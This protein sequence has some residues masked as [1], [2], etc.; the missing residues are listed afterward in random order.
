MS[1]SAP[2]TEISAHE[3]IEYSEECIR[4]IPA[5]ADWR[6]SFVG[7]TSIAT[8][9]A[10]GNP[11]KAMALYARLTALVRVTNEGAPGWVREDRAA[12]GMA[13]INETLFA[14]AAVEPLVRDAE[15]EFIFDRESFLRRTLELADANPRFSELKRM[16]ATLSFSTVFFAIS[17]KVS[18]R[19]NAT[20]Y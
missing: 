5:N 12:D 16:A 3:L 19:T 18:I 9:I 14:A 20:I 13:I 10:H 4:I 17:L 1:L 11:T 2:W 7:T 6:D 15:G 8:R